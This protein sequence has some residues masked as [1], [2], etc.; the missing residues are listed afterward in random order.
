MVMIII[1]FDLHFEA[2]K[3]LAHMVPLSSHRC[4][5]VHLNTMHFIGAQ[6]LVPFPF[7]LS[8]LFRLLLPTFPAP[9]DISDD[10]WSLT[11]LQATK[12][13]PMKPCLFFAFLAGQKSAPFSFFPKIFINSSAFFITNVTSKFSFFQNI[14][15]CL[16]F[17]IANLVAT[18]IPSAA[19]STVLH[20]PC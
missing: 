10:R 16:N 5:L 13:L 2:A 20:C 11:F 6:Q 3:T 15:L 9:F 18:C 12:L 4:L 8:T 17:D 19:P 7:S 14:G 1:H